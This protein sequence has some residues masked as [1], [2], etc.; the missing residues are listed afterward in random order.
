MH[1]AKLVEDTKGSTN[2]KDK[3]RSDLKCYI[4]PIS[5]SGWIID[6]AERLLQISGNFARLLPNLMVCFNYSED[7]KHK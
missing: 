6:I 4:N 2:W 7:A 3:L 5:E 1:N